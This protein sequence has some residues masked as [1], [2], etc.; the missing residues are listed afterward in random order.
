MP[1]P[2]KGSQEA[3]D[4]MAHLRGLRTSMEK[5]STQA[6]DRMAQ[7][8]TLRKT[9]A[10]G[11]QEAKDFMAR[12]RGLR[13]KSAAAATHDETLTLNLPPKHYSKFVNKVGFQFNPADLEND[14]PDGTPVTIK[15][16]A[17]FHK[18]YQRALQ[19]KKS[20][21]IS[22]PDYDKNFTWHEGSGIKKQPRIKMADSIVLA[23]KPTKA[24]TKPSL[25]PDNLL[26]PN[27][28]LLRGIPVQGKGE[29]QVPLTTDVHSFAIRKRTKG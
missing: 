3:K 24:I 21:R 18:R 1:R 12:L 13:K 4:R 10:K 6:K 14:S 26:I 17:T 11:S 20:L 27:G 9:P 29:Y 19:Q 23:T 28:Q 5:G 2:E 8:R 22:K 15:P 7:L 16:N 25:Q